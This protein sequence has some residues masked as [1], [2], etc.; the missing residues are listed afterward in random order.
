M[1][2]IR[3]YHLQRSKLEQALPAILSQAHARGMR[4]LVRFETE[5]ERDH[6]NEILWT[7]DSASFLPHDTNDSRK[8]AEQ[9]I[10]LSTKDDNQN[11]A[12]L[13]VLVNGATASNLE[14]FELCCEVFDGLNDPIVQT[15][16]E[17]WKALK[18]EGYTLKYLQ[19]NDA[20]RWE[21]KASAN[22][23]AA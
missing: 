5:S 17:K 20:G 10:L 23:E 12:N 21:E 9:N 11:S 7:Y 3:F 6:I 8:P 19:Q 4:A 2:E 22:T 16:R 15:M 14:G 1:T 18:D 13:L